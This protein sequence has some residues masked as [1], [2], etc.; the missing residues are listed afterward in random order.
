MRRS[1][2]CFIA[3]FRQPRAI[4]ED[5]RGV[6]FAS[7]RPVKYAARVVTLLAALITAELGVTRAEAGTI[8]WHWAGPVTDYTFSLSCPPGSDCGPRL[9][10]V[11]PLGT[12]VDLF[13]S[14][15]PLLPPPNPLRPC[16]RGTASASFQV[17]GRT[18]TGTGHVWDE[19]HGFGSGLCVPG[20]DVIEVV[21]PFWGSVGGPALPEGWIPYFPYNPLPGFGWGGDLTAVQPARIGAQFPDFARP[22]ESRPQRFHADLQAVTNVQA[23]PEPST[24][25]LLGTGLSAAWWRRRR[26]Q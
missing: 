2:A 23:V 3:V 5:R 19:A 22:L 12:T 26:H 6:D 7:L 20:H 8:V 4:K 18:Y 15:D 9:E 11:V 21:V 24:W 13:L 17:L 10:S 1:S 14:F 25:L 16:Y